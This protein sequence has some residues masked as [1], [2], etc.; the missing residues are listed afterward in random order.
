MYTH[1]SQVRPQE[2]KQELALRLSQE[3]DFL[4]CG[5]SRYGGKTLLM[6]MMALQFQ[7]DP[8]F[9]AIFFRRNQDQLTGAGSLYENAVEMYRLFNAEFRQKPLSATFPSGANCRWMHMGKSDSYMGHRGKAYSMIGFDEIDQFTQDEVTFLMTCLRSNAKMSSFCVG[10]CNPSKTWVY[11]LVEWY[12][13]E[14]GIPREDRCGAVRYFVVTD[15]GEFVFADDEEFFQE[16]YKECLYVENPLTK[17]MIYTPPKKFSFVFFTIFDNPIGLSRN[18]KYLSELNNQPEWKR[19]RE[20]YGN[21]KAEPQDAVYFERKWLLGEH[22]EKVKRLEQV[23]DSVIAMRGIDKAHSEP[24]DVNRDPDYTAWSPKICKDKDGFYWLIGDY[25]PQLCDFQTK[26]NPDP[27]LGRVRRIAG[28][29]DQLILQQ[30]LHDGRECTVVLAK[31]NGA[32]AQDFRSTVAM[33]TENRIKVQKDVSASNIAEKKLKD[34]LPFCKACENGLV[35][36]VE[37]SFEPKSLDFILKEL[38]S[39]DGS[40]STR[41]KHD[42]W[43]DA[44]SLTFNAIAAAKRPYRTPTASYRND[45][46]LGYTYMRS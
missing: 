28:A 36:I 31:D 10:T 43:V 8:F 7:H 26:R 44:I 33:L 21:W 18:P 5:G 46:T 37:N 40:K 25:I 22:R 35:Y 23:P 14:D 11:P 32:G 27:P 45:K 29:R 16:N 6:T 17:E 2:G 34:F 1:A 42:D 3:V 13:D 38:E 39:F 12:L 19:A 24:S 4:L 41:K 30:A 20:L 9:R 15:D